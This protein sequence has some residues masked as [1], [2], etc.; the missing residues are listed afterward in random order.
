[1][2][3]ERKLVA[4]EASQYNSYPY[5]GEGYT[6]P[7]PEDFCAVSYHSFDT[8]FNTSFETLLQC[9]KFLMDSNSMSLEELRISL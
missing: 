1:M 2:K 9:R 5:V 8:S 6:L 3:S 4:L 7:G